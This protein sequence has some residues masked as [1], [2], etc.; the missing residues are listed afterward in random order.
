MDLLDAEE[1]EISKNITNAK[2]YI[3]QVEKKC[4]D[5]KEETDNLK[6]ELSSVIEDNK[7]RKQKLLLDFDKRLKQLDLEQALKISKIK[8]TKNITIKSFF[9]KEEVNLKKGI[10]LLCNSVTKKKRRFLGDFL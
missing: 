8:K 10:F 6:N 5:K 4:I 3:K 2:V 1:K 7:N 9:K